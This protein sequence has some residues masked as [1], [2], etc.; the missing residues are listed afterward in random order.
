MCHA[1]LANPLL[2]LPISSPSLFVAGLVH[3]RCGVDA[4]LV[5]VEGQRPTAGQRC[6]HPG[7]TPTTCQPHT[8]VRCIPDNAHVPARISKHALSGTSPQATFSASNSQKTT[9]SFNSPGSYTVTFSVTDTC[10]TNTATLPVITVTCNPSPTSVQ[11]Q[12]VSADRGSGNIVLYS[13]TGFPAVRLQVQA[14]DQD[15]LTYRW[16][17]TQTSTAISGTNPSPTEYEF[18]PTANNFGNY[19]YSI[20][21]SAS[22]GCSTSVP[23]SISITAQCKVCKQR[24]IHMPAHMP[25]HMPTLACLHSHAYT[26]DYVQ[27]PLISTPRLTGRANSVI[28]YDP[29]A[30]NPNFFPQITVESQSQWPYSSVA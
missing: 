7:R 4:A 23:G 25:T 8:R 20:Q 19:T 3:I 29:K 18:T 12:R 17:L 6:H 14:I 13:G 22:D 24:P 11:I 27:G 21:A 15:T 9:I 30:P 10:Q 28:D 16:S 2:L 1:E 5:L 26:H